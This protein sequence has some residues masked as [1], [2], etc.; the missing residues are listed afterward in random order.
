ML[1]SKINSEVV[2]EQTADISAAE[3]FKM[4]VLDVCAPKMNIQVRCKDIPNRRN[5]TVDNSKEEQQ[6]RLDAENCGKKF[7]RKNKD[8]G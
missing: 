7:K 2:K 5:K 8:R 4:K 6:L 3:K 1:L